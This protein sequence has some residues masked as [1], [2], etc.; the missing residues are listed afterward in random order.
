MFRKR[1]RISVE[2][3]ARL[4]PSPARAR[5]SG[6][7][8]RTLPVPASEIRRDSTQRRTEDLADNG[9]SPCAKGCFSDLI[10]TLNWSRLT[11]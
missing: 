10:Q 1:S 4:E 9:C 7:L 6:E 8:V 11:E 3:F 5:S 2:E